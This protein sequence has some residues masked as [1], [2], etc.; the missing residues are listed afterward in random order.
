MHA[1]R[2]PAVSPRPHRRVIK[3]HW[4]P[5]LVISGALTIGAV[6][7]IGLLG[8]VALL[9]MPSSSD[10]DDISSGVTVAGLPVG[11]QPAQGASHYLEQQSLTNQ[12]VRLV[13]G[14]RAWT[15]T[16]AALGVGVDLNQTLAMARAAAP[17]T[18]V[19]PWYTI[20]LT[21][22]QN[23]LVALSDQVNVD[24]VRNQ[25]GRAMEIPVMLNRLY[26]DLR[27]E[28][29]DRVFELSMVEVD[30]PPEESVNRSATERTIHTVA[31]GEELGLIARRYGVS[32]DDILSLNDIGDPNLIYAGQQLTIPAAGPYMPSAANAPPAPL[33]AGKSILVSTA[34]QR[35]YAYENGQFVRSDLVSTGLPDTPTVLGDYRVYV[36]YTATD[37]SGPDYY[38]PQVP[39][40]MYFFEGY[41]IHGTYWHN[42]FGRPMSHGCVNLPV[43]EAQ[44]YFNWA[45]VGTLVR[46]I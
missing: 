28:L 4:S 32:V 13:D 2:R 14:D 33:S 18:E 26:V 35:I 16:L 23:A 38:L 40:T 12:A 37:M 25:K 19:T 44:W 45:E 29:G 27:G 30:A 22:T 11:G 5:W 17:N 7:L 9:L 41:A 1:Q 8:L 39:Y 36:K 46:V 21:Q 15:L 43:G 3:Q 10:D 24:A 34:E 42:S 31:Q 6:V 20:D